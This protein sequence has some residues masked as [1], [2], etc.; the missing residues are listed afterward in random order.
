MVAVPAAEQVAAAVVTVGA[1]GTL[2]T[3]AVTA[4]RLAERHPVVIF[5]ACA[6]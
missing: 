2:F 1:V 4:V 5:R 3:V 6:W